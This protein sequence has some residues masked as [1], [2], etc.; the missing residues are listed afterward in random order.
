MPGNV[1]A[2]PEAYR[3]EWCEACVAA[4][5]ESV[6]LAEHVVVIGH[7]ARTFP[8]RADGEMADG[9]A[10]PRP[11]PLTVLS[12][13]AAQHPSLM[14]GTAVLIAPLHNPVLLAKQAATLSVLSGG[15]LLLGLGVGWQEEEF[16]AVGFPFA[17]RGVRIEELVNAMRALWSDSPASFNGEF[18]AFEDAIHRENSEVNGFALLEEL[19]GV[20]RA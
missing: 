17:D 5:A 9:V 7:H 8:Y 4:G 19:P 16:Q 20:L 18:V 11:D 2:G 3:R 10:A 1:A 13:I 6:W 12:W 15:R 14:V